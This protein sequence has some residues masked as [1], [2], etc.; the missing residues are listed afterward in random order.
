MGGIPG[1]RGVDPGKIAARTVVSAVTAGTVSEVTGG[2]FAN[3]AMTAAF[4]S[5]VSSV[6]QRA[7]RPDFDKMTKQQKVAWIQENADMLGLDFS[8]VNEINLDY[9]N[10]YN[11]TG[12]DRYGVPIKCS[13]DCFPWA[14]VFHTNTGTLYVFG[15]GFEGAPHMTIHTKVGSDGYTVLDS[16]SRSYTPMEYLIHTIGHEVSHSLGFD[17]ET[18]LH[19]DG[20]RMGLEAVDRFRSM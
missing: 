15:E 10:E 2:K 3:G 5:L 20:E 19:I 6:A 4:F 1:L 17:L 9:S 11:I 18:A 12:I 14:G 8:K 16:V 13:S 7:G